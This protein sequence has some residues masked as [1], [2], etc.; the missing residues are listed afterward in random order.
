MGFL[1]KLSK[2]LKTIFL[3]KERIPEPYKE[4]INSEFI[5]RTLTDK[6][7]FSKIDCVVKTP[8]FKLKKADNG[9]L[10]VIRI[11]NLTSKQILEIDRIIA[12]N[13]ESSLKG[14][15]RFTAQTVFECRLN[16]LPDISNNQHLRHAVISG[17]TF[18]EDS[19]DIME[20]IELAKRSKLILIDE[21]R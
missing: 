2:R 15:A 11:D 13:R 20:A 17:F 4:I 7:Q 3:S 21:L 5:A 14:I 18:S 19:H 6:R 12:I 1:K 8:A 10:S 9:F 16:I